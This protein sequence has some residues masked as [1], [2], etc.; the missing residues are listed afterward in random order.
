MDT[1]TLAKIG[2]T[3]TELTV[4]YSRKVWRDKVGS[5]GVD[6]GAKAQVAPNA[7]P[8]AVENAVF[9]FV[10]EAAQ[11]NVGGQMQQIVHSAEEASPEQPPLPPPVPAPAA[12]VEIVTLDAPTCAHVFD[13]GEDRLKVFGGKWKQ[14]GVSAYPEVIA[15][16]PQLAGWEKWPV[17]KIG[18]RGA[19]IENRFALPGGFQKVQVEVNKEGKP[20]RVHGFR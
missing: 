2:A 20:L 11:R 1:E 12:E 9:E 18:S 16:Y 15:A 8:V 13:Q 6:V 17:C 14:W 5:I 7:D 4:A 3:V 19:E 10:R